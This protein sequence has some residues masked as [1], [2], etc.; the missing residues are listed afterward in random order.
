VCF[1]N[2]SRTYA[3]KPSATGRSPCPSLQSLKSLQTL[4]TRPSEVLK[5]ISTVIIHAPALPER[6]PLPSPG[7]NPA[8]W[9]IS[10]A[11]AKVT[12][13]ET[14]LGPYSKVVSVATAKSVDGRAC[15]TEHEISS[16]DPQQDITRLIVRKPILSNGHPHLN[17][18][19]RSFRRETEKLSCKS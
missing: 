12:E 3:S 4:T 15:C 7:K 11:S 9:L 2:R 16:A 6:Q 13:R 5:E 18:S 10:C 8:R 19:S 1:F 17:Q 14:N